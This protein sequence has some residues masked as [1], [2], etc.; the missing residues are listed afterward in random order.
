MNLWYL[1][2][3]TCVYILSSNRYSKHDL[4]LHSDPNTLQIGG[5]LEQLAL[6][7]VLGKCALDFL[8]RSRLDDELAADVAEV[9]G[10]QRRLDKRA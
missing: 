2:P 8:A 7:V 6:G 9:A 1:W 5:D 10:T 3:S 4:Q